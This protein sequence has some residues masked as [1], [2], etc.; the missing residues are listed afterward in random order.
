MKT[1]AKRRARSAAATALA[2]AGLATTGASAEAAALPEAGGQ[3][4]GV[5]QM[6]L[7]DQA[8]TDPWTHTGRRDVVVSAFYP[9]RD[10]PRRPARYVSPPLGE[11]IAAGFQMPAAPLRSVRSHAGTDAAARSGRHPVVLLM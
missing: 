2:A 10:E 6:H 3:P 4:V 9:A 11:A 1:S 7:V 5:T 8:R